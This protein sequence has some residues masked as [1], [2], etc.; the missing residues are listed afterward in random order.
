MNTA[1]RDA[2]VIKNLPLVRYVVGRMTRSAD[3]SAILDYEDL[4]GSG[5]EGLIKAVTSF[6]PAKNSRFSTWAVLHIRATVLD[7]LRSLDPLPRSLRAK[8]K[9]IERISV[10]LASRCGTWP[11][12]AAVA[13]ALGMPVATLQATM[14]QLSVRVCSLHAVNESDG[15]DA[16][17]AL[18]SA[19]ADT[20]PHLDPE[21]VLDVRETRRMVLALVDR[22]PEREAR[23]LRMHYWQE[24]TLQT[25]ARVLGVSPSRISQLHSRA[26][27]LLRD[28]VT[29]TPEHKPEHSPV[30]AA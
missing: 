1:E 3:A 16:G 13:A 29:H 2:L 22:L 21:L 7:A 11:D 17:Y 27:A 4:V 10:D 6:D 15:D 14:R 5:T 26:L 8:G 12:D 19:L 23:V 18:L 9:A 20:D 24:C 30:V 25:I 28:I